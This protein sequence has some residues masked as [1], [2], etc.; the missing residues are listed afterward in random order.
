MRLAHELFR[1]RMRIVPT[2]RARSAVFKAYRRA[3]IAQ[4]GHDP[5]AWDALMAAE[6]DSSHL[7]RWIYALECALAR[8]RGE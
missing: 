3:C 5:N 1:A 7:Q 8:A 2:E 4:H 6:S